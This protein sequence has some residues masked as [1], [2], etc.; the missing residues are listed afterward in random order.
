MIYEGSRFKQCG[1]SFQKRDFQKTEKISTFDSNLE[2]KPNSIKFRI[3]LIFLW[4]T[5]WEKLFNLDSDETIE[6]ELLKTNF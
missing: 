1:F 4:K 6:F 5:F 2:R 3:S